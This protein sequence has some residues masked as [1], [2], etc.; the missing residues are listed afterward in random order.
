MEA[1]SSSSKTAV[2]TRRRLQI[3]AY[4]PVRGRV[5]GNRIV[6][7][8]ENEALRPGPVGAKL[9]IVDFDSTRDVFLPPVDLDDPNVLKTSGLNP[10]EGDHYFHQQMVYAVAMK[11]V[12]NFERALGR[13]IRFRHNKPLRIFPH[14]FQGPNAFDDHETRAVLS[15][16]FGPTRSARG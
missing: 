6:V 9:E 4:D 1:R 16:T 7:D 10:A 8:V 2:P 12:E 11:T 5:A 14:A 13:E 15:D 3:Y